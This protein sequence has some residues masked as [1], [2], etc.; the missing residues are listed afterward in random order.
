MSHMNNEE[1]TALISCYGNNS[2]IKKIEVSIT[3][4]KSRVIVTHKSWKQNPDL[5]MEQVIDEIM[6]FCKKHNVDKIMRLDSPLPLSEAAENKCPHCNEECVRVP[7][8]TSG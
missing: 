8:I 1:L 5:D 6:T 7:W 4:P 2:D 3:Y